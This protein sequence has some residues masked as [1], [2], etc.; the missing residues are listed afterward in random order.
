M[1]LYQNQV[2]L[3]NSGREPVILLGVDSKSPSKKWVFKLDTRDKGK[4]D[5]YYDS[6]LS[7]VKR[8]ITN[9]NGN[10]IPSNQQIFYGKWRK[11]ELLQ[12]FDGKTIPASEEEM[13]NY[14]KE[15]KHRINE[16]K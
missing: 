16:Q 2:A 13:E 8:G 7:Y 6:S 1:I 12:E 10:S 5:D 9:P 4:V 3:I 11:R 15:I 14:L